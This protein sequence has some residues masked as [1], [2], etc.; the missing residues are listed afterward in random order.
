MSEKVYAHF[1]GAGGAG[2]SGIALVLRQRGISVTGSDLKESRYSKALSAAGVPIAIGHR[3]ENL[4]SPEVVVVSTAIPER[5]PELAEA[6]ERGLEIWPRARMLANLA[7]DLDTIAV[8]GTHGKTSTSSMIATML[9]GMELDPTFLIGGEVDGVNTNALAGSGPHYVVEADESDGSFLFLEPKVAVITNIEADHLDH[10]SSIEE[11]ADTFVSFMERVTPDGVLVICVD[12]E[13]LVRLARQ[14][15]RRVVTFG[16][17]EDADVRFEEIERD[18][19]GSRFTTRF[20]D[21]SA[22]SC[23]TAI[24][25]VH[26]VSN[27]CAA[28]ATAY[29]LGL[30]CEA[31]AQ[32]LATFSGVRRRFDLV[33]ET[34]GITVV[35]DYAHHPT[36]VAATLK[37]AA[38]LDFNRVVAIFQP[39]RYS[40][41]QAFATD[42][43]DAFCCADRV[44]LMD[45]YTAGEAPIP[46][47]SGKTV[48]DALLDQHPRARAAYLPHRTD[49]IGYLMDLLEPGDLV[50]TMGAGDVTSV[51]PELVAAIQQSSEARG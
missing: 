44:V 8:A 43:G 7:G 30:D 18:G 13:R 4:G 23:T 6:R 47:I 46:G 16:A 32:A 35:D 19:I 15:D 45:V 5:N 48:L 31:A 3:A 28:L 22:V 36:E 25:G 17:S 27:S 1:I 49:I 40:R 10:Y 21:G 33:G 37:A 41:T 26:M 50:L 34:G 9:R 29:A 38:G 20:A 51:G 12:D 2:M 14:S 24:P 39:H 11:I 42:F